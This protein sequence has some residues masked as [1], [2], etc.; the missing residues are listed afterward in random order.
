LQELIINFFMVVNPS[1]VVREYQSKGVPHKFDCLSIHVMTE[2]QPNPES[3]IVLSE[4]KDRLGIPMARAIWKISKVDRH[5]VLRIGQLLQHELPKAG[6]PSPVMVDWIVE[7]RPNNAP[8][9]DMAHST[10]TTRMS[11]DPATGVVDMHLSA[12]SIKL[13]V[14][15][16]LPEI[17]DTRL[18]TLHRIRRVILFDEKM[19]HAGG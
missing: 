3:R 10:G 15:L 8:L 19:T 12:I 6:L 1:F 2:Q 14:S 17:R 4:T 16:V 5:N 18:D 11:N 9:V 13:A 7:N